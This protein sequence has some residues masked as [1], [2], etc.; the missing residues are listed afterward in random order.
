M[1]RDGLSLLYC[2]F[3]LGYSS[4]NLE[5]CHRHEITYFLCF[6]LWGTKAGGSG[7][8]VLIID[9][10][11]VLAGI[12]ILLILVTSFGETI[13]RDSKTPLVI[14]FP[15][16]LDFKRVNPLLSWCEAQDDYMADTCIMENTLEMSA[17]LRVVWISPDHS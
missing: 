5:S 16:H 14:I 2:L 7:G 3:L 13:S 8:E 1:H 4:S 15:S 10:S 17:S 9:W 12:S 11:G 6:I